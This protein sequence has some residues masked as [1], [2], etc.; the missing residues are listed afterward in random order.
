MAK[1]KQGDLVMSKFTQK[2]IIVTQAFPLKGVNLKDRGILNHLDEEA[3]DLCTEP[4][5]ITHTPRFKKYDRVLVR[6]G[7]D[8]S[9]TPVV[10]EGYYPEAP[11]PYKGYNVYWKQCTE[12]DESLI[13]TTDKPRI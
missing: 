3:F 12:W 2:V 13:G 5:T 8:L 6:D 10:Y 4:Y 11:Y 9:W 7:D 1:F